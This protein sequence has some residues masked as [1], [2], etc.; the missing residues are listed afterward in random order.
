[1]NFLNKNEPE[2]SSLHIELSSF[3][4]AFCIG[5]A[6]TSDMS[7]RVQDPV[8]P[9]HLSPRHFNKIFESPALKNLDNIYLC[10]VM[11]DPLA[12]PFI[13][14]F[15]MNLMEA[16]PNVKIVVH[17]NGSLGSQS[18]W[19]WLG[20]FSNKNKFGNIDFIIH[21]VA[22]SDKN[23]LNGR[24]IETSKNNFINS[25]SISCYS[26]TKIA[27]VFQPVINKNVRTRIK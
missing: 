12:S 24:Y 17:T 21:A 18:L 16:K 7:P 11:G 15:C 20:R 3:C 22:Y 27:K 1:M 9:S 23:E 6:R 4:N 14:S 13:K 10:G 5:C 26:F 25:L 19:Q 2:I 8:T